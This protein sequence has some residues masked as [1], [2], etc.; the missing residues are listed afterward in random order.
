MTK[1]S[2]L[3]SSDMTARAFVRPFYAHAVECEVDRQGRLTIDVYKRQLQRLEK[4]LAGKTAALAGPSGVGK[5]T[6]LTRLQK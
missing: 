5:S 3:P 4:A 1:L 6:I 2:A